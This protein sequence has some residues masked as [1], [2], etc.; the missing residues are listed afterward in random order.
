MNVQQV[1]H[2]NIKIAF[3]NADGLKDKKTELE[4][5]LRT[6]EID[7]ALISETRLTKDNKISIQGYTIIRKDRVNNTPH[8]GVAI[9]KKN[10][11][12]SHTLDLQAETIEVVAIQIN[13]ETVIAAGYLPPKNKLNTKDLD[14][15]FHLNNRVFLA[16]DF[17]SKHAT[18]NCRTNNRNGNIIFKYANTHNV[19]L[20]IPETHT[21]YPYQANALPST[22]DFAIYKNL[23]LD[24][25][26]S[27]NDLDSDHNP[28]ITQLLGTVKPPGNHIKLKNYEQ[29]NWDKFKSIINSKLTLKSNLHNTH[30]I[31]TTVKNC[32][33]IIHKAL[34]KS[35]PTIVCNKNKAKVLP[36]KIINLIKSRNRL[37]KKFQKTRNP[38]HKTLCNKL[39][40]VIREEM[41]AHKN[42]TWQQKLENIK[43]SSNSIWQLT[44]SL[45][46][47]NSK[48]QTLHSATGLIFTDKEKSEAIA[49][50]FEKVHK[51]TE[52]LSNTRTEKIVTTKYR[53]IKKE[54][55][56]KDTIKLTS[57]NEIRNIIKTT[58]NNK[59]PGPDKIQNIVL[60][61]LPNKAIVQLT[62]I[63]NAC[64]KLSY[65]PQEWK[66]ALILPIHKPGKDK[67]FPQSYRPISLLNTMSKILENII[68]NRLKTHETE[69]HQ[70]IPEQFGFRNH[71]STTQQ[72]IRIT[73]HI[74]ENFN[75]NK[76]T[77]MTLLDIEKAFD[78]VWHKA[79][80]Y[81]L[82]AYNI[83]LYL[84]KLLNS[85]L[86]DRT[87][88]VKVN[89]NLSSTKRINAGVPQGS[90]L[91]PRLF[92][93]YINDIPKNPNTNIALFADDTAVYSTSWGKP[94]TILDT[95]AHVNDIVAFFHKWK[96]K[97]N[98]TKTETI[99]FSHKKK[100]TFKNKEIPKLKIN[101]VVIEPKKEVKYLGVILDTKLTYT[102]HIKNV[103]TK[104][105]GAW[106]K[107]YSL[108]NPKSK[109]S[110]NNKLKI[111]KTLIRP[112]MLYAAPV[113]S[114]T[115]KTNIKTLQI[116]Q[117]KF[118]RQITNS[119][120]KTKN[121]E[122]HTTHNIEY[123]EQ[124]IRTH[125][126]NFFTNQTK[127]SNLLTNMGKINSINAPF[128]LKYK[129]PHQI[130]I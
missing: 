111:Y 92:L 86:T 70:L 42:K 46:R 118:L 44:K 72:L 50:N 84:L 75:K 64:L 41:I 54:P 53:E 27:I 37:R 11:I 17:N 26:N 98:E 102:K 121:S 38:Q 24:S 59:A 82:H 55:M 47:T 43:P 1:S 58:R 31:D 78:T 69:N 65:F 30:D 85:F 91:G 34:N 3:W 40:H 5:F 117:N 48:I 115:N 119:D 124:V 130:L 116:I 39:T 63:F 33:K 125:T 18:W 6:H 45:T 36:T 56:N 21:H 90:I 106:R 88:N 123:L 29:A 32:T 112:I 126:Q 20:G 103:K 35:V 83:P 81:K 2:L 110:L 127:F 60:K 101:N 77:A 73:N 79:L 80:I 94:K 13:R 8:G 120:P 128:K 10:S 4:H 109:L 105:Y 23:H 104:T 25:I 129:L 99:I 16:G 51:Q 100:N 14:K 22:I 97:V 114:N 89:E 49:D 108:T 15:I 76:S 122:I 7:L 52:N 71:H 68:L 74:S 57:P 87:F 61:N 93:Y 96:L 62:Y 28:I 113:W 67:L 19:N 95:Q 9:I 66:N 107:I 12:S